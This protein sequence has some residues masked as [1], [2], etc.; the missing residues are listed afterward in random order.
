MLSRVIFTLALFLSSPVFA[1]QNGIGG[2]LLLGAEAFL[3]YDELRQLI[4]RGDVNVIM[5]GDS[6]LNV[7]EYDPGEVVVTQLLGGVVDLSPT[8]GFR[9]VS[10]TVVVRSN[11]RFK[12]LFQISV[13]DQSSLVAKEL[14]SRSLGV[15][16]KTKGS[17]MIEGVMN[18]NHLNVVESSEVELY[19]VDS[20]NLDINVEQGDVVIAG[21]TSF[22]TM[23]GLDSANIDAAG[24]I[25][26]RAWVSGVESARISVF[27][28]NELFAYT[29]E[30]AV[31]DVKQR[32]NVY[33]PVN[34]APSAIVLNYVEMEKRASAALK[35]PVQ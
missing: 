26:K 16:I 32:P 17:V 19:W 4:V 22:L 33:A 5:G 35:K 14:E 30:N 21:R 23:R 24:L 3:S 15:D 20:H 9:V 29:K 2:E 31:I 28:T 6:H 12:D 18:L 34:Q 1:N 13:R 7:I 8:P 25:A 11:E 10:P 27:P